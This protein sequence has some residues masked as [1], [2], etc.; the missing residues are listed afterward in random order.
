MSVVLGALYPALVAVFSTGVGTMLRNSA[1]AIAAVLGL[2]LVVPTI[3]SLM[4]SLLQA[5]WAFNLAAFLPSS[6][7]STMFSPDLGGGMPGGEIVS[8]DPGQAALALLGWVVLALVGGAVLI[9][10]RDV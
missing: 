10:R 5:T 7:G 1:G 9:K 3:V 8:L 4:G 6:L 2:L